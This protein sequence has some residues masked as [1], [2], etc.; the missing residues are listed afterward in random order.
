MHN[1]DLIVC[2]G[3]RRYRVE[4]PWGQ[5]FSD[6]RVTDVA[7]GPHEQLFVLLRRDPLVDT[8]G[9]AVIEL[10]AD[11]RTV[12]GWG[13]DMIA[14]AHMLRCSPDGRVFI[15][16]RDAHEVVICSIE[17]RKLGSLGRRHQPHQPFNHPTCV[18][19]DPSGEVYVSDGY[20]NHKIHRFRHDGTLMHSWGEHG[21]DN[22]QFL[23]PHAV[24]VSSNGAVHVVDRGNNRVQVF[25][26]D[27]KWSDQWTG[28]SQPLGIWGD[29]ND[30]IFVTDLVPSLSM[31]SKS[32]KLLGRCRPVLNGAHGVTGDSKGNLYLAE[33]NPSR[34]TRLQYLGS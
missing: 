9:D 20:A 33:G 16:D 10:D 1:A 25:T 4:R 26:G 12:T 30:N 15:V 19:F 27:G 34:V 7:V 3:S 14:D 13:K 32:G 8:A 6:G 11:G 24:W 22:G 23:N 29:A 18:A 2:L 17:G 28:L 21:G 31:F 5:K